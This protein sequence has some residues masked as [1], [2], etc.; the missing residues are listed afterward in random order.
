MLLVSYGYYDIIEN[1][2]SGENKTI[3]SKSR[4]RYTDENTI[5]SVARKF[6][7]YGD[8]EEAKMYMALFFAA[9]ELNNEGSFAVGVCKNN[10]RVLKGGVSEES[11]LCVYGVE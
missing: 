5:E 8:Y 9:H 10:N 11:F 3:N 1:V 6:Y 4:Q 7:D 2:K